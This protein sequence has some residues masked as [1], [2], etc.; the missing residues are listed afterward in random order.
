MDK[1]AK[2]TTEPTIIKTKIIDTLP[3]SEKGIAYC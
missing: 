2:E 3:S 1:L